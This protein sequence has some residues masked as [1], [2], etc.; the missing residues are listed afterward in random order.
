[1]KLTEA[2][3]W[4]LVAAFLAAICMILGLTLRSA[5]ERAKAAERRTAHAVF[6]CYTSPDDREHS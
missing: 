2:D 4:R 6:D 5:L 3:R 1:M